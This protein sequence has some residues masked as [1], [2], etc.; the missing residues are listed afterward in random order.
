MSAPTAVGVSVTL[1]LVALLP[2]HAS[3]AVQESAL[4]DD[5]VSVALAPSVIVA[6][7]TE[8]VTVGVGAFTVSVAVLAALPPAPV[9]VST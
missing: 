5:Q 4:V 6:G 3:L 7:A 1:P 8:M 9:Q 2:L